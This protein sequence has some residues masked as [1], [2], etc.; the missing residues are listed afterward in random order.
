MTEETIP[1]SSDAT[2]LAHTLNC[3][4]H[5][6]TI[7][8]VGAHDE[9]PSLALNTRIALEHAEAEGSGFYPVNPKRDAVFG[10]PCF[11]SVDDVPV[12]IDLLLILTSDPTSILNDIRTQ[13]PRVVLV[14]GNG[15]AETGTAEGVA[16][17]RDLVIAAR[18]VGARVVGPNTNANSLQQ[19]APL[20]GPKIALVAQSGHQGAPI[21]QAQELGVALSYMAPTGNEADLEGSEFMRFF[22]ADPDTAVIAAYVEGFKSG[23][24]LRHAAVACID[25]ATP[26][27]LVKVGR[28]TVGADMARSHTGH[29]AG[30]DEVFDAFFKQYG[31]VRVDDIDELVE[32]SAALARCPVPTADGVVIFSV[33]GGTAAHLSDLAAGYDLSLPALTVETQA[34]LRELVPLPLKISNPVDNGGPAMAGGNGPRILE[35]AMQDPHIGVVLCPITGTAPIL[36]DLLGEALISVGART[37]KAI[38]PIWSGPTTDHP[39]YRALWEAGFPV[40][41]NFR[42]ALTAAKALLGH[43]ART[44][45]LDEVARLAKGLPPI[46]EPD[47]EAPTRT[48]DEAESS[49]WLESRGI[50]FAAHGAARSAAEAVETAR[51]LGWPVVVKALGTDHKSDHGLVALDLRNE[52]EVHTVAARMLSTGASGVTVARYLTGGLE[53]LLGVSQDPTLGPV[54]VVGAGGVNAEAERDVSRS[55]LPVT[56]ARA[57]AMLASLRISRRFDGWRGAPAVDRTAAVELIQAVARIAEEPTVVELDINPLL[58][59]HDGAVGLDALVRLRHT[60]LD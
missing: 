8:V 11:P 52:D 42:N 57:E 9:R 31:M 48:L 36:T 53:L 15:F 22:A 21:R 1:A 33:S 43:P 55:V 5:P 47:P 3:L 29:L 60:P 25:H 46:R 35:L 24:A 12:P 32:V 59:R 20:S 6:E 13:H 19:L 16:R 50:P 30:S 14:F 44:G 58:L 7:C 40:M 51:T 23:Q 26:T 39:V 34:A 4:Y 54:V 41:R 37:G 27:V 18:R 10:R 17:E 49:A 45:D 28:S 38:L 56:A 2:E